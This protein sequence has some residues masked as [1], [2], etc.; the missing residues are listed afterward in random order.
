VARGVAIAER[1]VTLLLHRYEELVAL[2]LAD[3]AQLRDRLRP[4]GGV[5]LALDG[6]QPDVG[7]EVL[8]VLR[9]VVSGEPPLARSLLGATADDLAPLLEEVRTRLT[10]ERA[11]QAI[12]IPRLPPP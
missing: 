11:E 8:G 3:A 1:I 2:R 9:D 6:L 4:Q 10:G 7:H 12:P 5:I